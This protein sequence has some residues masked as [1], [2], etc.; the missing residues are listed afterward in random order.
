MSLRIAHFDLQRTEA[1]QSAGRSNLQLTQ[2]VRTLSNKVIRKSVDN[3]GHIACKMPVIMTISAGLCAPRISGRLSPFIVA[4]CLEDSDVVTLLRCAMVKPAVPGREIELQ[5]TKRP[6][7]GKFL[8]TSPSRLSGVSPL[9]TCSQC[10]LDTAIP[11][12]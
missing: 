3:H 7:D 1:V 2:R 11:C 10:A 6:R 8:G 5:Q 4:N 9:K 12:E